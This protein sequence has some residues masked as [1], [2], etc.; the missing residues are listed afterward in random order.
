[1][2]Y[3][4][5]TML[6]PRVMARC[7]KRSGAQKKSQQRGLCDIFHHVFPVPLSIFVNLK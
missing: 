6:G 2:L 5:T 4:I 7:G 1:V 3:F